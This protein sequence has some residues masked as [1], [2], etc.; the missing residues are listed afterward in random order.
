M[1]EALFAD[2]AR[3]LQ[4][5]WKAATWHLHHERSECRVSTRPRRLEV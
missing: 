4:E 1:A 5:A 2:P 3:P